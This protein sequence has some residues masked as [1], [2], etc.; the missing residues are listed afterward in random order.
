MTGFKTFQL[1][2]IQIIICCILFPTG[3]NQ[4]LNI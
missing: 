4:H 2:M 3:E 1:L